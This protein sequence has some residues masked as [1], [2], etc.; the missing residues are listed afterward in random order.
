MLPDKIVLHRS[1]SPQNLLL[2]PS[3]QTSGPVCG[4]GENPFRKEQVS[5]RFSPFATLEFRNLYPCF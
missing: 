3:S 2:R 5:Y 4:F 1:D